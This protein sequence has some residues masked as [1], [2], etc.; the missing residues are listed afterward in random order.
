MIEA[1]QPSVTLTAN[2]RRALAEFK[3]PKVDWDKVHGHT[4]HALERKKLIE[5][6]PGNRPG[7]CLTAAGRAELAVPNIFDD[8]FDKETPMPKKPPEKPMGLTRLRQERQERERDEF[9][10][11]EFVETTL[12]DPVRERWE[13]GDDKSGV[14]LYCTANPRT[15]GEENG[16]WSLQIFARV[17]TKRGGAGKHFATNTA[18]MSREDLAWLRDQISAELRRTQ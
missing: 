5:G 17:K 8:L 16:R 2:E 3:K 9:R 1:V 10:P 14:R 4:L 13:E 7:W 6:N 18:S 15:H 12:H 11:I